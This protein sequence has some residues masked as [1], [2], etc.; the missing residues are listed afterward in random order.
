MSDLPKVLAVINGRPF[1]AYLL[2]QLVGAGV[3]N[4][5]LCTGYL[6]GLI[7]DA[8]GNK[9]KEAVIQ[10]SQESIPLGTGGALRYAITLVQSES[11]M[12]MNGDSYS[13]LNLKFYIEWHFKKRY[14]S[15]L[16][17]TK[18][19]DVSRYGSVKINKNSRVLSFEEKSLNVEPGW[20]N[21]GV[22]IFRKSIIA[23]I[24]T[25]VK[26]SLE[27]ELLPVLAADNGLYGFCFNGKFIDIGTPESYLSAAYFL[28]EIQ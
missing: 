2:D 20:I 24:P 15:S 9:Y 21:G 19:N 18:I 10:Y 23:S 12:V 25:G 1:L 11:V 8:F 28:K 13:G 7:K 14:N 5:I 16:V 4:I 26:F 6:G 22:Y 17:L 3:Q 27:R